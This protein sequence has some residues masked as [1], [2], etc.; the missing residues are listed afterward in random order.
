MEK[1]LMSNKVSFGK[2]GHKYII[3][4]KDDDYKI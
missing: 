3:G 1:M 2:K 4:Y